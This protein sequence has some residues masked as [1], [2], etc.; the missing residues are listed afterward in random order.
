MD[1]IALT[2]VSGLVDRTQLGG[3]AKGCREVGDTGWGAGL[4]DN[5]AHGLARHRYGEINLF[6]M[7]DHRTHILGDPLAI[8]PELQL[9]CVDTGGLGSGRRED[10]L[11]LLCGNGKPRQRRTA[12]VA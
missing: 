6:C 4:G 5:K 7:T 11:L 8:L 12:S 2:F 9:K 10:E 3:R 1:Y